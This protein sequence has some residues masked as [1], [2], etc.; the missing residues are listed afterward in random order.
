MTL[1]ETLKRL[2]GDGKPAR[3][4]DNPSGLI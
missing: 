2:K 4:I 1:D 3:L